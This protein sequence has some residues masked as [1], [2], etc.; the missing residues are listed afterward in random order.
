MITNL[1]FKLA[2]WDGLPT[3]GIAEVVVGGEKFSHSHITGRVLRNAFG[4][5]VANTVGLAK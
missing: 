2:D 3:L 4:D 1:A 5:E